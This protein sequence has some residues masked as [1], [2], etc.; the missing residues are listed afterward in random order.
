VQRRFAKRKK[1]LQAIYA[2]MSVSL[3]KHH[4]KGLVHIT[5]FF[6]MENA[7]KRLYSVMV[8]VWIHIMTLLIV[9]EPAHIMIIKTGFAILTVSPKKSLA[10]ENVLRVS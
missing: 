2:T 10:M 1:H 6:V 3:K 7:R 8:N 9:M 5:R 4:V